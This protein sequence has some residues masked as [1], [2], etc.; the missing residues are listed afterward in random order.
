MKVTMAKELWDKLEAKYM[1]KSVENKLFLK[2]KLFRFDYKKG[3]SMVEHLDDFNKIITDLLNLDVISNDEDKALLLLNSLPKSLLHGIIDLEFEDVS[4]ALMNNEMRKEEKEAYQDSSTNVLTARGR[5]ST[6]KKSERGKFRSKSRGRSDN[7]RKLDKNECAYCQ[8]GNWKK[9]C[10]ILKEKGSKSN[11]VRDD[12]T[13]T[14][15]ALTISLSI[16]V[17]GFFILD[18]PIICVP[19]ERCF[20]TSKSSMVE[21]SIWAMI[22]LAR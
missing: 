12:D 21:L 6:W 8:K 19:T 5:T 1:Q 13:D 4:N 9:D 7:W 3:I 17:N 11:V 15:N 2:K 14:D 22:V 16:S 10:P 18:A 20:W